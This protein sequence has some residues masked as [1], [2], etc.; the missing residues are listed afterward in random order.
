[1]FSFAIDNI[2]FEWNGAH[3]VNVYNSRGD[4]VDVF[5][6][7]YGR[8]DYTQPEILLAAYEYY[9]EQMAEEVMA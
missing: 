6:M 4:N 1:M 9:Q 8:D 5:S 2:T 7:H 3:T